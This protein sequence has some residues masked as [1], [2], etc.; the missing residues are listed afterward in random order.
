MNI[1]KRL[2]LLT[3]ATLF[4]TGCTDAPS[5][6][7]SKNSILT[8]SSEMN[9]MSVN[10]SD[11]DIHNENRNYSA[12]LTILDYKEHYVYDGS[13]ISLTCQIQNNG[14]AFDD[15]FLVFV[16]GKQT[17]Y[18]TATE[19]DSRMMHTVHIAENAE[20][21]FTL[22]F[23]PC[24][25]KKGDTALV[26]IETMLNPAYMLPDTSF[27]SF[28]PN[29]ALN[30][31]QP[32][33]VELTQDAPDSEAAVSEIRADEIPMTAEMEKPYIYTAAL[34]RKEVH[35]L[36]QMT[37]LECCQTDPLE[38]FMQAEGQLSL[39]V[40]G[41][42][43]SGKYL[44]GIYVDHHLQKAFGGREYAVL[45]V[46][47]TKK[48]TL[49]PVIDLTG[50][51]G[52]HHIYMIAVPYD[53]RDE[54]TKVHPIKSD[55]KLLQIGE[56]DFTE[57]TAATGQT[58]A[59]ETQLQHTNMVSVNDTGTIMRF[60]VC[61]NGAVIAQ[62][63][64]KITV[65]G[66]DGTV[67]GSVPASYMS[68]FQVLDHGFSVLDNREANIQIY[69]EECKLIKDI[70]PPKWNGAHYIVSDD[71][72]RI[73]YTY[74]D[75]ENGSIS[76]LVTDSISLNDRKIVAKAEP[77]EKIG[78]MQSFG[79]LVSYQS[80]HIAYTGAVLTKLKPKLDCAECYGSILE[81]GSENW[82]DTLDKIQYLST[83]RSFTNSAP[84][85]FV[86][87]QDS[88]Q[89]PRAKQSS[90]VSLVSVLDG[91]RKC[92]T[93]QS[94]DETHQAALSEDGSL[95][96][97]AAEKDM[98]IQ[99]YDTATGDQIWKKANT[100]AQQIW[101]SEKTNMIYWLENGNVNREIFRE[102]GV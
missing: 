77:S 86:V 101:I 2:F 17:P 16:N 45:D 62:S 57:V 80:G 87:L 13:P 40:N 55:T 14:H 82:Y 29:H 46:E 34:D 1:R 22:L 58:K 61:Q 66:A 75:F 53:A 78:A 52:L 93:C 67:T 47:R 50:M 95:F 94:A 20:T 38:P 37:I 102:A 85:W 9:E 41:F 54:Y 6:E 99:I 59:A 73:A 5:K 25:C 11:E 91:N 7:T 19:P 51:T 65:T 79:S 15:T 74:T 31:T 71:G 68:N 30:G 8:H 32:F 28:K 24:G 48:K 23:E 49:H 98:T 56:P 64:D 44:V 43:L 100:S 89:N 88:D 96:A 35:Q 69:D 27:V 70:H 18:F 36:D 76:Y 42:G 12:A 63:A 26:C 72:S 39:T 92:V 97:T 60:G 83:N 81:S 84:D 3:S 4:L 10:S 90:Q 21:D 33:P